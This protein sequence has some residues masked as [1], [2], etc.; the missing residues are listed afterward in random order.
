MLIKVNQ[1][2]SL[3]PDQ[4]KEAKVIKK[5]NG[6]VL[7][8]VTF[9]GSVDPDTFIPFGDTRTAKGKAEAALTRIV[10]ASMGVFEK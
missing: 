3:D 6:N 5:T 9:L 1:S 7:L 8:A 2:Y 4:V 10:N